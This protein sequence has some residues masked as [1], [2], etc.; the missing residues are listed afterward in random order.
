MRDFS[1]VSPL[2]WR[3]KRFQSLA[4]AEAQLAYLYMLTCEHQT[5]AGAYRVPDGYASADLGWNI[6]T[7]IAART[8]CVDAGLIV[9]DDGTSELFVVG[10][11]EA[12]P[13]CN[14]K[15]GLGAE[16]L[17]LQ[18]DSDSVREKAEVE[19]L[20]SHEAM[21]SRAASRAES[22]VRLVNTRFM[23]AR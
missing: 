9:Y 12:N 10:W 17:I 22:N 13:I 20:Q 8:A 3:D 2:V 6:D 4:T 21:Q 18:I 1:K 16:R 11:F 15:H 14:P 23:G 19:Y 5:S 7:W